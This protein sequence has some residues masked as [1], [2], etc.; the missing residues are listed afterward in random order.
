[1]QEKN[2]KSAVALI[3]VVCV[4]SYVFCDFLRPFLFS[5]SLSGLA[6]AS[7]A[8]PVLEGVS[9]RPKPNVCTGLPFFLIFNHSLILALKVHSKVTLGVHGVCLFWT[10]PFPL[11]C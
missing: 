3:A 9:Q 11:F 10:T 4:S 5:F 7:S 2:H 6:G 8:D 1:M